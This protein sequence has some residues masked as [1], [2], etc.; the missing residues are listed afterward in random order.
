MQNLLTDY[1]YNGAKPNKLS[2][3]LAIGDYN[4]AINEGTDRTYKDAERTKR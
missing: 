1:K 4:T 2:T 3:A